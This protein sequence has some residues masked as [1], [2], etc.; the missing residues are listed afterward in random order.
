MG[1]TLRIMSLKQL[2]VNG[3]QMGAVTY[4]KPQHPPLVLLHGFTGSA[5][6]WHSLFG[7]LSAYNVYLIA[8]DMLGHGQS[9]APADLERYNIEHAQEDILAAL[10]Q[11]GVQKGQAI[12]LGYSMGG[13]IALYSAFSGF[14]RALI[15]ES[16]SPGLA[17]AHTRAQRVASD[18]VLADRIEREGVPAFVEYWEQQPLF[19]GLQ[20]L[21]DAEHEELHK[22]RLD[23]RAIGLANSLRGVGTGAQPSLYERLPSLDIP[24]LLLTGEHDPKFCAIARE[25]QHQ[26]PHAT[27]DVVAGAGHTIHL[28]QP[29]RFVALVGQFCAQMLS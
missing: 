16:T 1:S 24:T 18:R 26:L 4:G 3:I 13:R 7:P 20:R 22:Q 2:M 25:M 12:L 8:L 21:P 27:W 11:L 17:D 5:L 15:L 14:F 23:N 19:E 28:E 9:D 6:A 10:Y 29:E